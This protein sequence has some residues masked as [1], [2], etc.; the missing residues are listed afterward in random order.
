MKWMASAL[1]LASAACS[2]AQTAHADEDP[3]A[4][5]MRPIVYQVVEPDNSW[6]Q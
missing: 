2:I 4:K 1:I 6:H 5:L 3:N